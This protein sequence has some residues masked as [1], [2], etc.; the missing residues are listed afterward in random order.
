[1]SQLQSLPWSV[2]DWAEQPLTMRAVRCSEA[3]MVAAGTAQAEGGRAHLVRMG[4]AAKCCYLLAG[5]KCRQD[6]RYSS[7]MAAVP[8]G[9]SRKGRQGEGDS[10]LQKGWACAAVDDTALAYG[11]G[12]VHESAESGGPRAGSSRQR[13]RQPVHRER[14]VRSGAQ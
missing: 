11:S 10:Q 2:V 12:T 14:R 1:M 13:T 6:V 8:V 3:L 9:T 4:K 7:G 5:V